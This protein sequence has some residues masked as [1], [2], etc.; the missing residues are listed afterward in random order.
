MAR[1]L[2]F[3]VLLPLFMLVAAAAWAQPKEPT[4]DQRWH[5]LSDGAYAYNLY[6]ADCHG[7]S[8]KGDGPAAVRLGTKVP[9]LRTMSERYGKFNRTFVLEHIFAT[10]RWDREPMPAWGAVIRSHASQSDAFALLA[11]HNLMQHVESMQSVRAS[12]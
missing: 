7:R 3:T 2:R 6:C 5:A 4:R 9:D 1:N 10:N 11:A 12:R 8:G